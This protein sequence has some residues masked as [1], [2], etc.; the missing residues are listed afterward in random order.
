MIA[1]FLVDSLIEGLDLLERRLEVL[2]E[3]VAGPSEVALVPHAD[4]VREEP[5]QV[6]HVRLVERLIVQRV[7]RP[8]P[9]PAAVLVVMLALGIFERHTQVDLSVDLD[10]VHL[11]RVA[12]AAKTLLSFA[13]NEISRYIGICQDHLEAAN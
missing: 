9:L 1:L 7:D 3:D 11:E 10:V 13:P 5:V 6:V 12:D 4:E 8:A 2:D